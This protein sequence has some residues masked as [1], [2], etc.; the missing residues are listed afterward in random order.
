VAITLRESAVPEELFG[1][2]DSGEADV[3]LVPLG[4]PGRFTATPVAEEEIVLGELG[5][6]LDDQGGGRR[7]V[8]VEAED[9]APAA[10]E[11]AG[12]AC[13]FPGSGGFRCRQ[14]YGVEYGIAGG[15]ERPPV[16]LFPRRGLRRR[17]R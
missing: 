8:G 14:V 1:F 4:V 17:A 10:G 6:D 7:L 9:A 13:A 2:I 5:G 15:A 3:L 12:T 11:G 16:R